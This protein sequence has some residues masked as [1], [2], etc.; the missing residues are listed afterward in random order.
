MCE[1]GRELM[2]AIKLHDDYLK[3]FEI[4]PEAIEL[5]QIL[6]LVLL[7]ITINEHLRLLLYLFYFFI[8][9]SSRTG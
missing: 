8:A 5:M 1:D 7:T 3:S 2:Q 4:H 9:K 6:C